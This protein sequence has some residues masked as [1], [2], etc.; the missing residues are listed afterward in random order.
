MN[1]EHQAAQYII[2]DMAARVEKQQAIQYLTDLMATIANAHYKGRETGRLCIDEAEMAG[3]TIDLYDFDG[4][5]HDFVE[6]L[7]GVMPDHS[8]HGVEEKESGRVYCVG[9]DPDDE[10]PLF[11]QFAPDDGS[12]DYAILPD[13]LPADLL[14]R[15]AAWLERAMQPI[16]QEEPA[17]PSAKDIIALWSDWCMD[18]DDENLWLDYMVKHSNGHCNR[19]HLQEKWDSC[20]N[21]YGNKAAMTMFWRQLDNTNRDILTEYVTEVWHSQL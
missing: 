19:Q 20:Y 13:T 17:T 16:S 4:D 7:N 11:F 3:I 21:Q 5:G 12:D 2:E 18:Y 10:E 8:A 1:R 9:Y 14:E 6:G 15:I